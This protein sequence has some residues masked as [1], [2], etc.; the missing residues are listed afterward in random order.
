MAGYCDSEASW[1]ITEHKRYE[2]KWKDL[3]FSLGTC[4]KTVLEQ[5]NKKLK[6]LGF[7]SHLYLV[8]KKGIYGK[9]KCNFDLYRVMITKHKDIVKLAEALLPLSRHEDKRKA[10]LRVINYE[11]ANDVKK[12]LKKK[13]LGTVKL[14]CIHCKHKKV[15][16]NGVKKYK[17]K[18]YLRYK[19]PACK[20]EFQKVESRCQT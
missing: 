13:N 5:I 14:E 2:G 6:E 19:C 12:L 16:R 1:V 20:K 8:R 17:D 18:K 9:M 7:N 4:D 11:K 10:K 3:I 15:W